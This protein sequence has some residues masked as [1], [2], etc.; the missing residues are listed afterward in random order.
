[1]EHT[2]GVE[3]WEPWAILHVRLAPGYLAR[4]M[5]IDQLDLKPTR[6]EH[7]E[8]GHPGDP[9]GLQHDGLDLPLLQPCG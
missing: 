9:G 6:F 2:R 3:L 7:C 1:M 5:S 8:Q 4:V